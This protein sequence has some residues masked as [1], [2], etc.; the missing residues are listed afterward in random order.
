MYNQHTSGSRNQVAFSI[1]DTPACHIDPNQ[2][3]DMRLYGTDLSIYLPSYS[4]T[5]VQAANLLAG[6]EIQLSA[7]ESI[8]ID[9]NTPLH[10]QLAALALV[11]PW[12]EESDLIDNVPFAR[13]PIA[14]SSRVSSGHLYP[15]LSGAFHKMLADENSPFWFAWYVHVVHFEFGSRRID[16][17]LRVFCDARRTLKENIGVQMLAMAS[18]R[19]VFTPDRR[20]VGSG[21][22]RIP[23]TGLPAQCA[24]DMSGPAFFYAP[25]FELVIYEECN[26]RT[27]NDLSFRIDMPGLVNRLAFGSRWADT[28]AMQRSRVILC[29]KGE[30]VYFDCRFQDDGADAELIADGPYVYEDQT[31]DDAFI[32]LTENAIL[33]MLTDS[34]DGERRKVQAVRAGKG[35]YQILSPGAQDDSLL[36]LRVRVMSG[37]CAPF[38]GFGPHDTALG[39]LRAR[40]DLVSHN[41]E[42]CDFRGRRGYIEA[43]DE[44]RFSSFFLQRFVPRVDISHTATLRLVF[45]FTASSRTVVM[46]C[47]SDAHHTERSYFLHQAIDG[48]ASSVFLYENTSFSQRSHT[49]VLF[50]GG[51]NSY[52]PEA[53]V[54]SRPAAELPFEFVQRMTETGTFS[55]RSPS[56]A[57]SGETYNLAVDQRQFRS[58]TQLMD[59]YNRASESKPRSLLLDTLGQVD[60]SAARQY[61]APLIPQGHPGLVSAAAASADPVFLGVNLTNLSPDARMMER[62]SELSVVIY[63][64]QQR[65]HDAGIRL[66]QVFIHLNYRKYAGEGYEQQAP[67]CVRLGLKSGQRAINGH[68]FVN[69]GGELINPVYFE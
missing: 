66:L 5:K 11:M 4:I 42:Y 10:D 24:V 68:T 62:S 38:L 49:P 33:V 58:T 6:Q 56:A 44:S 57:I 60:P 8:A 54:L 61:G 45:N 1:D 18:A 34:R 32:S 64:K 12:L 13:W 53:A 21:S 40:K 26:S 50:N 46:A 39:E 19:D 27:C 28:S 69:P 20:I 65:L 2:S 36:H 41:S 23:G 63:D 59:A 67:I 29:Y 25:H 15:L 55:A 31:P 22:P 7:S 37:A 30:R 3:L 51:G 9:I 17:P 48:V 16:M 43:C 35:I 52:F 14:S 47:R